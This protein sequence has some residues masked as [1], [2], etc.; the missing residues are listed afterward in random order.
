MKKSGRKKVILYSTPTCQ[1]CAM[2]KE[3]FKKNKISFTNK[4]VSKNKK[5]SQEMYRKSKQLGV[6]V[7]DIGGKI[8]IGYNEEKF[9]KELGI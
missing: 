6:P 4:D 1:W 8:I 9:R 5:N 7:I 3:F 2:T